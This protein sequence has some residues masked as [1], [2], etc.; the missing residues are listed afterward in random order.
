MEGIERMKGKKI[1]E[2]QLMEEGWKLVPGKGVSF[3]T[4]IFV[5]ESSAISW[6]KK[7]HIVQYES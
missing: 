4:L 2:E 1:E 6:N 7:T 3:D 5:K